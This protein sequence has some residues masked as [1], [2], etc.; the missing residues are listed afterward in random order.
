MAFSLLICYSPQD[1]QYLQALFL[2]G[3]RAVPGHGRTPGKAHEERPSRQPFPRALLTHA[4]AT[5]LFLPRTSLCFLLIL[6]VLL[7]FFTLLRMSKFPSPSFM[8]THW[9]CVPPPYLQAL[10]TAPHCSHSYFCQ[11]Q[12]QI[13]PAHKCSEKKNN[14]SRRELITSRNCH[15]PF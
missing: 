14:V 6:H 15:L 1:C 4:C 11:W 10:P 12:L 7:L 3:R 9:A 13:F 5:V 8:K 2:S